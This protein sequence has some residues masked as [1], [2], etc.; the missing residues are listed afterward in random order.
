MTPTTPALAAT[1]RPRWSTPGNNRLCEAQKK[2]GGLRLLSGVEISELRLWWTADPPRPS[3]LRPV[4]QLSAAGLRSR[5]FYSH[6]SLSTSFGLPTP[7][8]RASFVAGFQG[9]RPL[10]LPVL[11]ACAFRSVGLLQPK[12]HPT[13]RSF[14]A[15]ALSDHPTFQSLSFFRSCSLSRLSPPGVYLEGSCLPLE[16]PFSGTTGYSRARPG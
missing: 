6:L 1:R 4:P 16:S 2:R 14:R 15:E 3:Q 13:S 7:P 8:A 5:A 10:R 9:L 11:P 12:L